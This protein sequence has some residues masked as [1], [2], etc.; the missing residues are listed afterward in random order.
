M[1]ETKI[2]PA[3]KWLFYAGGVALLLMVIVFR[4]N[5]GVELM[6]FDGLGLFNMPAI[7]PVNAEDW[8]V[9]FQDNGLLGLLLFG[10]FDLVNYALLG[11]VFLA[12][13]GALEKINKSAMV[14]ANCVWLCEYHDLPGHQPRICYAQS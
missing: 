14:L 2:D 10:L 4:R 9:L 5:F 12:L 7:E 8:F 3:W 13:Y 6:T 11:I 1:Q